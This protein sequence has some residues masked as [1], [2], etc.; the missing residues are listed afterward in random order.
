MTKEA[1]IQTIAETVLATPSVMYQTCP[2]EAFYCDH[3]NAEII[4]QRLERAGYTIFK[5]ERRARALTAE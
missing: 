4:L 1:I 5:S 3:A 2:P